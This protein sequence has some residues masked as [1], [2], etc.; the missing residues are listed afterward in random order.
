MCV[1]FQGYLRNAVSY[2]G[3]GRPAG[4]QGRSGSG[5]KVSGE[6]PSAGGPVSQQVGFTP[7]SSSAPIGIP[8]HPGRTSNGGA[9]WEPATST[10]NFEAVV[11][12]GGSGSGGGDRGDRPLERPHTPTHNGTS[13]GPNGVP[14]PGAGLLGQQLR[15]VSS[16]RDGSAVLAAAPSPERGHSSPTSDDS[17]LTLSAAHAAGR[18]GSA[19]NGGSNANAAAAAMLSKVGEKLSILSDHVERHSSLQLQLDAMIHQYKQLNSQLSRNND[20]HMQL[21]SSANAVAA[22]ATH[23]TSWPLTLGAVTAAAALGVVAGGLL[24]SWSRRGSS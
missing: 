23:T 16:P 10:S 20:L 12:S 4:H 8:Q 5:P 17:A 14:R 13:A 24:T 2:N 18:A 3:G 21:C 19:A 1:S 11:S 7:L 9:Q 15:Q 6:L 22:A